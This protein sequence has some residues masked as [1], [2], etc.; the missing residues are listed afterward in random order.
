MSSLEEERSE[1]LI[2]ANCKQLNGRK[3]Q[4]KEWI[5]TRCH[6]QENWRNESGRSINQPKNWRYI[7]DALCH[8]YTDVIAFFYELSLAEILFAPNSSRLWVWS[9][10]PGIT[11]QRA[12]HHCFASV[13]KT[14]RCL[15]ILAR[16]MAPLTR[17]WATT[18]MKKSFAPFCRGISKSICQFASELW[19]ASAYRTMSNVAWNSW[20]RGFSCDS[21]A[22]G[23]VCCWPAFAT[24]LS[25]AL[26]CTRTI[27]HGA[28]NEGDV[29]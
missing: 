10:H 8:Q 28:R 14:L 4:C 15:N 19:F 23:T 22:W 16:N 11:W 9:D 18:R 12:S 21:W 24:L 29:L 17:P 3:P 6:T 20:E 26:A 25:V 27:V 13:V 7:Q 2:Q 1:I 5:K